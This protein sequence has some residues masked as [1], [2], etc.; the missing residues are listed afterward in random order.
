MKKTWNDELLIKT[1]KEVSSFEELFKTF[2]I[3]SSNPIRRRVKE[4][5]LNTTHWFRKNCKPRAHDLL[6]NDV[7][8]EHSSY[9]C[10]SAL[11]KKLLKSGVLENKCLECGIQSWNG[12]PLSLQ[13][14]H[15]NGN[16]TDNRITNLRILCPNCHSQTET[17]AGKNNKNVRL[18]SN[19]KLRYAC[20]Y[21]KRLT[22]NSKIGVCKDCM[23]KNQLGIYRRKLSVA[24]EKEIKTKH[25]GGMSFSKLAKQYNVSRDT[26]TKIVRR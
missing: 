21:C 9:T 12:K 20:P 1:V 23:V 25:S 19:K 24:Q 26:I 7:L 11:K 18:K 14:D 3:K 5:D 8:I 15:I 4:L 13:L 6:L 16:R 22:H 10:T 17:Y 2:G